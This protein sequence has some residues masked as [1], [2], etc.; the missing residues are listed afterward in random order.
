MLTDIMNDHGL[1]H[2]MHYLILTYIPDQFQEI[3][4]QGNFSDHDVFSGTL[5]VYIAPKNETSE[6]GVFISERRF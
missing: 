4:S 5:K 6:E 2:L 1:E 3:H